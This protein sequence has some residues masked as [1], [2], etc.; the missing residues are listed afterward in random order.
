[1]STEDY[2][3]TITFRY[4]GPPPETNV[5]VLSEEEEAETRE[6]FRAGRWTVIEEKDP[7]LEYFDLLRKMT[8]PKDKR[9]M[10]IIERAEKDSGITR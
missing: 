7:A 2:P 9:F 4:M 3:K 5:T 8:D 10:K 1:M 6:A